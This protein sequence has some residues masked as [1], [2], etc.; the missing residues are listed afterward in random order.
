MRIYKIIAK[1]EILVSK[2]VSK[3]LYIVFP[4]NFGQFF[5]ALSFLNLPIIIS[6][7]TRLLAKLALQIY[8]NGRHELLN[9]VEETASVVYKDIL[10]WI[11]QKLL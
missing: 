7:L 1:E 9:E 2:R 5:V 11:Q 8:K 10:D 6:L 3:E 4:L